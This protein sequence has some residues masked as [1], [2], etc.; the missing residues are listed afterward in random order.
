MGGR[1]HQIEEKGTV[2][3]VGHVPINELEG[4]LG[5]SQVHLVIAPAWDHEPWAL[6]GIVGVLFH[7][8]QAHYPVVLDKAIGGHIQRAGEDKAGIKAHLYRPALDGHGVIHVKAVGA[9]LLPVSGGPAQA[10]MPF[11]DGGGLVALLLEHGGYSEAI[12][13]DEGRLEP[14]EHPRLEARPPAIAPREDAVEAGGANGSGRVGVGKVHPLP[15][16]AVHVGR[17]DLFRA[18][19]AQVTVSHVIGHDIDDI[20]QRLFRHLFSCSSGCG[21]V[22][23]SPMHKGK[24]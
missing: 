19:A 2:G 14:P 12:R 23:H 16:Q 22:Y 21:P 9:R 10:H 15:R 11:A 17:A 1:G 13:L 24:M 18:I 4:H 3:P 8:G 7:A 5:K 20:G 6:L